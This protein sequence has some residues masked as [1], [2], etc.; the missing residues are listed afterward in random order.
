M[1][2]TSYSTS[3]TRLGLKISCLSQSTK[4]QKEKGKEL[5]LQMFIDTGWPGA[6]KEFEKEKLRQEIAKDVQAYLEAGGTIKIYDDGTQVAETSP[7]A[8]D[9]RF[10]HKGR[11]DG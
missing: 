4:K 9:K 11:E 8:F 6:A 2:S 10:L 1:T 5:R 7:R 3:W